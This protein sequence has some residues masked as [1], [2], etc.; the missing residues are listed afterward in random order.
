MCRLPPAFG[1]GTALAKLYTMVKP[2]LEPKSSSAPRGSFIIRQAGPEDA[3]QWLELVRV[4]LGDNYPAREVYDLRWIAAQLDAHC[5]EETWVAEYGGRILASAS[6][7]RPADAN[8]NPVSNIGRNLNREEAYFC[9]AAEAL[10]CEVT[11]QAQHLNQMAVV[12]VPATDSRQQLI[13]EKMGY[14][15]VGYQP[16]KHILRSRQG[17]LFY[18][19]PA[20]PVLGTRMPLSESLPQI[21]ELATRV[22][23][24]LNIPTPI[25]VRDGATGY[26]LQTELD[27]QQATA[28]DFEV[29]RAQAQL[30]NP[31]AEVSSGFNRNLGLLRIENPDA[32]V[33]FLLGLL[34]SQIVC[35]MSYIFDPHDKCVRVLECFTTN[36]YSLGHLLNHLTKLSANSLSAAYI[37]IDVLMSAPRLLKTAEQL[38]FV[39]VAY[40][41]AFFLHNDHHHDVVKMVKLNLVYNVESQGMTAGAS[42]T[43]KIVDQ[44]LQDQKVGIAVINLLRSL[45][46]FEGL[47]DGELRK[48]ARLFKQKLYQP[49]EVVFKKADPGSEAYIVM[50]GQVDICLEESPRPIATVSNGQIFGELAFLDGSPRAARAV[51]KQPS[52]ILVMERPSFT[53]LV[54]R[55]PHLGL[56]VVRN[57]AEDL[58][59]KLRRTNVAHSA[60]IR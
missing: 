1:V 53:Q 9:G 17:I 20:A 48:V 33:Q 44:N 3:A 21:S 41:P 5:G 7:L 58:S 2:C 37:E 52:I 18:V 23:S 38:G 15:C 50:R 39:P 32:P 51:S 12:R 54:Q 30:N 46:L 29:W 27:V 45:P 28:E 55:E 59:N 43:I 31:P 57:L 60:A 42:A 6:F 13:Y 10:I 19:R 35:G 25:S 8:N 4:N 40:L 47:G 36:D 14:V 22:L 24:N 11:Q 26:P 34:N 16:C 56:V 49:G